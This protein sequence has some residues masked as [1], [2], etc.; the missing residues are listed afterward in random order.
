MSEGKEVA[1]KQDMTPAAQ[2]FDLTQRKAKALALS[3]L[4]PAAYSGNS[5]E[6]MAKCVIAAE[7]AERMG[8]NA[9]SV[10]QNLHIIQQKPSWSSTFI[11]ASINHSKILKGALRFDVKQDGV[12]NGVT[13]NTT[14]RE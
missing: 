2:N 11:I 10:A 9:V 3:G 7:M 12:L 1:V 13:Y 8:M 14:Q 5:Q 4:M 6:A